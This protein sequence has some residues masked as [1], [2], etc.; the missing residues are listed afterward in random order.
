MDNQRAL[1]ILDGVASRT[2]AN[3]QDH[4]VIKQATSVLDV[5]LQELDAL[6]KAK[7]KDVSK[8]K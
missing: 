5:A 6:K 2:S 3:R 1:K 8:D 4:E 7:S